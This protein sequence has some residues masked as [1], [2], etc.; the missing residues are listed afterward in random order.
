M[1][2]IDNL[3]KSYTT[4]RGELPI[5]ANVSLTLAR[6]QAAAIMGP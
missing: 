2:K 1:L 6:G 4:P 3:S 5:L